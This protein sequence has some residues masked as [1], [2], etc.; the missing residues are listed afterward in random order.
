GE[1]L[2]QGASGVIYRG[3]WSS[4]ETIAVAIKRFKGDITS[5]GLPIDEMHACIAAGAHPNL[6]RVLGKLAETDATGKGLVF[7][8][9]PPDYDNLGGPPDLD[10]CTR[11]TY[12]AGTAFSL[13]MVLKIAK[14]ISS[15][16]AHLHN[17]GIIH[18]DLYAHNILI[19]AEGESFLGDFGAASFYD[20]TD[21]STAQ[22]L[23]RL[24]VR[25][26]GCLLEDLLDRCSEAESSPTASGLN[27]TEKNAAVVVKLR[28]LQSEC[29][30]T[31]PQLRPLFSFICQHLAEIE[32]AQS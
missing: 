31:E 7:S 5:D 4:T 15:A 22:A 16:I 24:E 8:V 32:L 12:S 11:D 19:N 23:E 10:T 13:P 20:V 9:I 1:V 29:M 14:G 17:R 18:G 30:A 3:E 2:G 21:R 27:A 26:F 6:V 28:Q 25:A